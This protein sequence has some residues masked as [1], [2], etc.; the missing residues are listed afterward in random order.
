[1]QLVKECWSQSIKGSPFY[2]WEEKLRRVKRALKHWAKNLPKPDIERKNIKA[3][4]VNHQFHMEDTSVTKDL[5]DQEAHLQQ[6]YNKA[7]LVEEEYW[8]L[9]SRNLWLKSGDR[10]TAFFHKQ[11]QSGKCH[12]T[13][14]EIKVGSKTFKEF[15]N[16]KKAAHAHFLKLYRKEKV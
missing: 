10:N 9:K 12:N 5:L 4:L 15:T 7:C 11:A 8:I 13:I 16:I 14:S 3:A 2:I 6:H 1:M